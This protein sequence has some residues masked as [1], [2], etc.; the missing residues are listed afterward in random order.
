MFPHKHLLLLLKECLE[1]EYDLWYLLLIGLSMG[2]VLLY[3]RFCIEMLLA[4][5]LL[6]YSRQR[7]SG[8]NG[9]KNKLARYSARECVS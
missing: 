4:K 7:W 8:S 1:R 3:T 9:T 6:S 5:E 2:I